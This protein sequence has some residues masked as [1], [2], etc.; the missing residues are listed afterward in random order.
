MTKRMW[1][2]RRDGARF[3]NA[4]ILSSQ[5]WDATPLDKG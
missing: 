1:F 3:K 4:V 5:C 2:T